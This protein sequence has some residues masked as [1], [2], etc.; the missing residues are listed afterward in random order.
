MSKTLLTVKEIS[1]YLN[2]RPKT[3][4]SWAELNRIPHVKLNG[5]L[6]FDLDDVM[7]WM[8]DCKSGPTG[9]K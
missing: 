6:R 9:A 1:L 5:C 7:K 4:Y 2:V 3:L 8:E